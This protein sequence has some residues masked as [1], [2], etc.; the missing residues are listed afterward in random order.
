MLS[1]NEFNNS[2]SKLPVLR[3]ICMVD[4]SP[5]TEPFDQDEIILKCINLIDKAMNE[6]IQLIVSDSFVRFT[7]TDSFRQLNIFW[8]CVT[9]HCRLHSLVWR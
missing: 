3:N 1:V 4:S 8:L 9:W 6:I 2:K 7:E 5:T